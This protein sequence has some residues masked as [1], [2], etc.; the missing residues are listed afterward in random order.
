MTTSLQYVFR[1]GVLIS[2][3]T[4]AC[5]D[6][7][8]QKFSAPAQA[9][10]GKAADNHILAQTVVNDLMAANPDLVAV[11]LHSVPPGVTAKPGEPGQVIVAQV[12]DSI[13]SPDS[14]GDLEVT[15][16]EQVRIYQGKLAGV[17]RMRVMAPL[18]DGAG[19][20]IGLVVLVFKLDPGVTDLS[21][22]AR[23]NGILAE[24]AKRIPD[25]ASLFQSVR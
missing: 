16:Q 22:H 20:N 18:R 14:P 9:P 2:S 1:A 5:A 3:L 24:I 6:A 17:A 4:L 25:Q 11:G 10:W 21:A 13:G 8:A 23:A 15:R 7:S 12:A 19:R